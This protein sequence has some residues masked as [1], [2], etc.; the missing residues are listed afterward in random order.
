[1]REDRIDY[2]LE[3]SVFEPS[4][5]G[6]EGYWCDE[7]FEWIIYSSHESSITIGGWLLPVVKNIWSHWEERVWTTPYF[8]QP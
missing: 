7:T 5:N 1:M 2:E 6:N 3:L 4:Y 8:D